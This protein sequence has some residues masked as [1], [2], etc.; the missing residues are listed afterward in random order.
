MREKTNL[1]RDFEEHERE[2]FVEQVRLY[3]RLTDE[4]RLARF[5]APRAWPELPEEI[6]RRARAYK[7]REKDAFLARICKAL[8]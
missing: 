7:D 3:R 6:V 2:Q 4:E 8:G 1:E 5:F